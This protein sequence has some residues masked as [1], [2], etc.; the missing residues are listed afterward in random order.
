MTTTTPENPYV[1]PLNET[2]IWI[3]KC[4][5]NPKDKDFHTQFGVFCE[6]VYE[7]LTELSVID[8]GTLIL[9]ANAEKAMRQLAQHLKGES[10]RIFVQE[11]NRQDFLDGL[12]DVV[13]T[14][15]TSS[16]TQ[17]LSI[18][19]AMCEVNRA[20][21]SKFVDGKPIFDANGKVAK[22]PNYIKADLSNSVGTCPFTL[23]SKTEA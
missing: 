21:F 20:N 22:G 23:A 3:E 8:T 16:H 13:V 11:S 14:A 2:K 9:V 15:V 19:D 7:T 12:C 10:G 18:V 17:G 4:L 5:P 1:D 6:E